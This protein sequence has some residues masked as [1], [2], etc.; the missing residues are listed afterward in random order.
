MTHG[1]LHSPLWLDDTGAGE[2]LVYGGAEVSD[3]RGLQGPVVELSLPHAL[4]QTLEGRKVHISPVVAT[5]YAAALF[6]CVQ[7]G[8]PV[9]G[10]AGVT[11][12]LL[13]GRMGWVLL[14]L[15]GMLGVLYML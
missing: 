2:K 1:G 7:V 5:G 3:L 9:R 12:Q 11:G 4:F 15:R 13:L 6:Q 14:L 10:Q 8:V